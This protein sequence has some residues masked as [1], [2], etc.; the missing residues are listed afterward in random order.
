MAKLIILITARVD[1]AQTIG[2]AWQNAGAPGVTVLEA[3]GIRQLQDAVKHA[4]VMPGMLSLLN[5][6]RQND[7]TSI[8]MLSAVEQ[9]AT[10][11]AIVE[12]TESIL[13]SLL[14]PNNGILLVIDLERAVGI[15]D[16]SKS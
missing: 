10:V 2:E 8:I 4:E 3:H 9:G 15:R 16:H 11:D 7:E 6:M 12:Q 13:G 1:E 14:N 5:I